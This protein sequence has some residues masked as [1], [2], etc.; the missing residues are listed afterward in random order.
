[1]HGASDETCVVIDGLFVSSVN[2]DNEIS[3]PKVYTRP[4]IP[5][6]T[7][8]IARKSQIAHVA[9]LAPFQHIIPQYYDDVSVGLLVGCNCSLALEPLQVA[10]VE[11]SPYFAVEY[12]HGWSVQGADGSRDAVSCNLTVTEC[13]SVAPFDAV[14]ALELDFAG[15]TS[16]HP[17]EKVAFV[18][19]LEAMFYQIRV[20][21]ENRDLLRFFLVL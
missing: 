9:K 12:R 4:D 6:N 11:G 8:H 20:S 1:M 5:T 21:E 3:L 15:A 14:K 7:N 13:H 17:D 18:G 2:G 10:T 19:D 16:V